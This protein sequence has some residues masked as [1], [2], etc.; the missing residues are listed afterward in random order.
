MQHKSQVYYEVQFCLVIIYVI[1]RCIIILTARP[2]FFLSY[3]NIVYISIVY[4]YSGLHT[5]LLTLLP[6]TVYLFELQLK[7]FYVFI[8]DHN[9][10]LDPHY[11]T[12][13]TF[14]NVKAKFHLG[15][16]K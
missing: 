3:T 7:H 14:I 16:I 1:V 11:L 10:I 13:F 6:V 9:N 5:T 2:T 12:T 8:N 15:N 4:I